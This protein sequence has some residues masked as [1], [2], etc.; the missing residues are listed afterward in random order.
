M[1]LEFN[2]GPSSILRIDELAGLGCCCFCSIQIITPEKFLEEKSEVL[3]AFL[4][5]TQ[6]AATYVTQYPEQAFE[7]LSESQPQLNSEM[8]KKI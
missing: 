5:A 8:Y 4:F 6:R 3:R 7:I 2:V 1:E